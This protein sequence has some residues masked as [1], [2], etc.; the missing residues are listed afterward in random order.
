MGKFEYMEATIASFHKAFTERE[1]SCRS[2]VEFYLGRIDSYDKKG[3]SLNSIIMVNPKAKEEAD[4]LDADF[5]ETG[6]LIGPLHGVPILLKDN[7]NT[8]D[9]PTTAGSLSLAGFIPQ[10]DAFIVKKLRQAG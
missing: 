10:N 1:I 6:K 8:F 7:F 4:K 9:M 5:K 2:L 3:P